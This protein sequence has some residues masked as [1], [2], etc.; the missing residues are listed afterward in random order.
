LTTFADLGLRPELLKAVAEQ[1]YTEP[2]PIQV[3]AIPHV[4]AGRDVMGGAQTGTGKTAGFTLPLLQRLVHHANTSVSPARHPVRALILAPTRE[5]AAQ[6]EESVRGYAKYTGLRS[7]VVFGGVPME[8]QTA[9]LRRGVEIL[10][11]TPGRL[12]DHVQ[13]RTLNLAQV[14]I[15]VLDEADRMLDMGFIPDVKRIIAL[16]IGRKQNLLFSATLTD[17]IRLLAKSFLRDP[18]AVQVAP[19]LAAAELVTHVVH[20]VARERK[21][22][23][24]VHL[25]KSRGMKQVL[26]FVATR[27]GANRLAYQLNREGVHAT[28]IHGDRT[29]VERMQ[30]LEDFKAGRVGVLVATDVAAR[31]LDIEDLPHVLNFDLPNSPE[32]YV[33]RIGRTGRAGTAGTAIS[34]VSPAEHERLA[35]IEKTIRIRMPREVVPGFGHAS[36]APLMEPPRRQQ[37]RAAD[38]DRLTHGRRREQPAKPQAPADPIFSRPYEPGV[39]PPAPQ[40]ATPGAPAKRERQIA[41]LLGGFVRKPT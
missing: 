2:T 39:A 38:E 7:T 28:A 32:D 5:L 12:L 19:K 22:E 26:V 34:L 11:A 13:Q 6:V 37:R 8:P 29:Q 3:Q 10:V 1:G 9:E 33:H 31:G 30:A 21:R 40:A 24:L 4:L 15:F 27:I 36:E 23:L 17:D 14:E 18:V 20:P 16:L 35:E 25:V 41:A